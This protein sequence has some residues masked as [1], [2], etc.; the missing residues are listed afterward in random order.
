M[1]LAFPALALTQVPISIAVG[2]DGT[3]RPDPLRFK[4][5]TDASSTI[6]DLV[7]LGA[8]GQRTSLKNLFRFERQ[9]DGNTLATFTDPMDF[10][11]LLGSSLSLE[12]IKDTPAGP[13]TQALTFNA[14]V[15]TYSDSVL[16]DAILYF[17]GLP[18]ASIAQAAATLKWYDVTP[19]QID[20]IFLDLPAFAAGTSAVY[21]SQAPIPY[22]WWTYY[23]NPQA[24]FD[25]PP[26]ISALTLVATDSG[27][28][29]ICTI[30]DPDCRR[31]SNTG[32]LCQ[33]N[34][35]QGLT[36]AV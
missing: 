22:D 31:Q 28:T 24:L 35:D 16:K 4:I 20:R 34:S 5:P 2:L 23:T 26:Q 32:H 9:A 6:S 33:L 19:E 7:L 3:S 13:V 15:D 11:T 18:G 12:I 29:A 10:D 8:N 21:Y 17:L 30:T 25:T 36:L 27:I 1:V 14:K